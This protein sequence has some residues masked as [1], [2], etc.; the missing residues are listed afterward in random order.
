[1]TL[2]DYIIQ[3][4][5]CIKI[6]HIWKNQYC[7]IKL[8]LLN[9]RTLAG[10]LSAVQNPKVQ[11]VSLYELEKNLHVSEY[12][13]TLLSNHDK[14]SECQLHYYVNTEFE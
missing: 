5:H 14:L 2:C 6:Y 3:K 12:V 9:G 1:M 7:L 13:I 11:I 10:V 4:N 8:E